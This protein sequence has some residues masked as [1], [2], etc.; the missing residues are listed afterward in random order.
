MATTRGAQSTT[1]RL[2]ARL[3]TIDDISL[4]RLPE[5]A[6]EQ[7]PSR[8]QVAVHAT[9]DGHP[10]ETV[11]EPDGRKGHWVRVDRHLQQAAGIG[12]GD[13]VEMTLE[14]APDW[15][16]PDVPEDLAAALDA[17]PASIRGV[18]EDI[19]PMARWE[20]VRWVR[21]TANPATRQRRVEV[22]ISK[23]DGGKRRPCCFDL[24]SCTEP[25]L[26][27]SGRLREPS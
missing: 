23:M 12:P 8:G 19:T 25:D 13:S 20:W 2:E 6:S 24:S 1:I 16:E 11:V 21:A 15:P 18:W 10:F 5:A 7:L 17:A 9:I 4:V 14:V 26:A 22:S 3:S 27:T